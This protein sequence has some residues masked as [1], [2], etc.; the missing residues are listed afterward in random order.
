VSY[1]WEDI[2]EQ[3]A[4]F[5]GGGFEVE[6]RCNCFNDNSAISQWGLWAK[7]GLSY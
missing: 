4:P 1:T 3:Y 7:G 2:D 6:W 5:L